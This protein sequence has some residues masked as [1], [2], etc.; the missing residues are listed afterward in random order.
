MPIRGFAGYGGAAASLVNN[1][2]GFTAVLGD[3]GKSG[4]SYFFR[5]AVANDSDVVED[6]KGS[7]PDFHI[8]NPSNTTAM[9][10]TANMPPGM[11]AARLNTSSS[12]NLS[13]S[14]GESFLLQ[15]SRLV[16]GF[17]MPTTGTGMRMLYFAN[18]KD[19]NYGCFFTD[20]YE[21]GANK[22]QRY[23]WP[24]SNAYSSRASEQTEWS[25]NTPLLENVWNHWRFGRDDDGKVRWVNHTWNGSS[26]TLRNSLNHSGGSTIG[27]NASDSWC[28]FYG[29]AST[30]GSYGS[31]SRGLIGY[32]GNTY[33]SDFNGTQTEWE[34]TPPST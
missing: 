7:W 13:T 33:W 3:A 6:E 10:A 20:Y 8:I 28:T 14:F 31:T 30:S 11:G 22:Y 24:A 34:S 15:N 16:G 18:K 32:W 4:S 12:S 9:Q 1:A 26:W 17:V 2:G 19:E 21:I 5:P 29:E 23:D 27:A 25:T